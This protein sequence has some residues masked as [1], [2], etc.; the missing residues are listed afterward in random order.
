MNIN[1]TAVIYGGVTIDGLGGITAGASKANLV[2]DPRASTLLKGSAGATVN[3]NTFRV[4]PSG[5]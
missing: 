3:K 2:F 1:G 5:Q 4:V